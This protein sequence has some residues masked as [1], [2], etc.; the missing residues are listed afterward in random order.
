MCGASDTVHPISRPRGGDY[1]R[2]AQR[3]DL[4][5]HRLRRPRQDPSGVRGRRESAAVAA[6]AALPAEIVRSC[7]VIQV[8]ATSREPLAVAGEATWRVPSQAMPDPAALVCPVAQ[9]APGTGLASPNAVPEAL[10]GAEAM[11]FFV[12][13]GLGN[14]LLRHGGGQ[15]RQHLHRSPSGDAQPSRLCPLT[16]V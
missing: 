10:A 14:H 4:D 2:A 3:Q 7:P 6:C 8:L 1:G 15:C 11:R 5:A 12:V 13:F 16:Q 9:A